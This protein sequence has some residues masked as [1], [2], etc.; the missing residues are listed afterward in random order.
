MIIMNRVNLLWLG[1]KA[2][3]NDDTFSTSVTKL[4]SSFDRYKKKEN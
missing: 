3:H 2:V 1:L 4:Y